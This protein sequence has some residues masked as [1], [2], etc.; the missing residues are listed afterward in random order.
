MLAGT[1][2]EGGAEGSQLSRGRGAAATPRP[3]HIPASA[4]ERLTALA[5]LQLTSLIAS[6]SAV[7][8]FV[9]FFRCAVFCVR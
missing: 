1:W 3:V 2:V 9:L 8:S 7:V 6:S 5:V 4:L